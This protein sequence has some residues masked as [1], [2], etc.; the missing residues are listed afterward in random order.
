MIILDYFS[1]NGTIDFPEFLA[2]VATQLKDTHTDEEFREAFNVF[3]K[4]NNGFISA[5]EVREVM[6]SLGENLTDEQIEKIIQEAD[7]DGD[8]QVSYQGTY[9]F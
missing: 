6:K 2:M 1:G 4:D 5:S 3:D 7:L 8:R 9:T